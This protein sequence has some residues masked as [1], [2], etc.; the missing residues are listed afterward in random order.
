MSVLLQGTFKVF[1]VSHTLR[2]SVPASPFSICDENMMLNLPATAKV[3]REPETI[4]TS[5]AK[6][7]EFSGTGVAMFC[8]SGTVVVS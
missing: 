1:F 4:D 7:V 3:I 6:S 2:K 8:G 5:L